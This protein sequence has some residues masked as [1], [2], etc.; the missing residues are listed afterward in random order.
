M[1]NYDCILL[2]GSK[3]LFNI[4]TQ[5]NNFFNLKLIIMFLIS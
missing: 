4:Y 2:F 1:K 3:V 5:L